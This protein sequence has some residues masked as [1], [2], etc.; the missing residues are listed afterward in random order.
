[1]DKFTNVQSRYILSI[2]LQMYQFFN[3]F[4]CSFEIQLESKTP[5]YQETYYEI[6]ILLLRK[7][8]ISFNIAQSSVSISVQS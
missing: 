5:K 2:Q 1:M 4:L 3:P 7:V 8:Q 6:G